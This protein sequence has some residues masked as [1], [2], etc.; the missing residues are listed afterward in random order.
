MAVTVAD[1]A[2]ALRVSRD[3]EDL[4]M[5]TTAILARL[6]GVGDSHVEL[7]IPT[8]PEP[9]QDE[10]RVRLAGYLYDAP[11]GRRDA[12]ANAWINSG[13]GSLASR[14]LN[15]RLSEG[16]AITSSGGA[17][18]DDDAVKALIALWAQ[19]SQ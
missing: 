16:A 1:L 3:G 15:Q 2:I 18:L 9:I 11:V 12:Y 13:A 8:A 7:L 17:P 19:A 6:L 5:A 4:D 10:V 14:W